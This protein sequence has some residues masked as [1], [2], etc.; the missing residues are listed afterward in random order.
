MSD[1]E[2]VQTALAGDGTAFAR[3]YDNYA[4]PIYDF[5]RS[6]LRSDADAADAS[7]DTFVA[8]HQKL[9]TLRQPDRLRDHIHG[10]RPAGRYRR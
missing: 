8:A 2:L 7:Q 5:C 10:A 6:T 9:S 1:A 3:I 4:T